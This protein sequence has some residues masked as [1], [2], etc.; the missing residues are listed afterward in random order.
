MTC[1]CQPQEPHELNCHL[2]AFTWFYNQESH[3]FSIGM[4]MLYIAY[5]PGSFQ[6]TE[7][8]CLVHSSILTGEAL[9]SCLGQPSKCA[10]QRGR[11]ESLPSWNE[12]R[13]AIIPSNRLCLSFG[14]I[15]EI[16]HFIL[17]NKLFAFRDTI[18]LFIDFLPFA[19][20]FLFLNPL[21]TIHLI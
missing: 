11:S 19:D 21:H 1:C 14:M 15:P 13:K 5:G 12:S 6:I 18:F 4:L 2:L 10:F 9:A 17:S 8:S 20:S 7:K 3:A 16:C